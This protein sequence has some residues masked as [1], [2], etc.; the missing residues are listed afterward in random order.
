MHLIF[1][2]GFRRK[3]LVIIRKQ[4]T[5]EFLIRFGRIHAENGDAVH[6]EE[7]AEGCAALSDEAVHIGS[8]GDKNWIGKIS[9]I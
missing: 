7:T 3:P 2:I 1:L 4:G 9:L 8:Y 6:G 5:H